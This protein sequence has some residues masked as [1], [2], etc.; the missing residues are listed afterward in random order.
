MLRSQRRCSARSSWPFRPTKVQHPPL[1]NASFPRDFQ[2]APLENGLPPLKIHPLKIQF[3][4]LKIPV[5]RTGN[6]YL[7]VGHPLKNKSHASRRRSGRS[8]SRS[9]RRSSSNFLP[10][11]LN[12]FFDRVEFDSDT[13][14]KQR[15]R[16]TLFKLVVCSFGCMEHSLFSRSGPPS[17]SQSFQSKF[18]VV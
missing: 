13:V 9:S 15:R 4:P 10:S 14:S 8:R 17:K 5:L 12:L 11:Q 7:Q 1:A 16:L 18:N 6:L 3:P 2:S